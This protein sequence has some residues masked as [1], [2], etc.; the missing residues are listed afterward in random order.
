MR[1][2]VVTVTLIMATCL[3][4]SFGFFWNHPRVSHQPVAPWDYPDPPE[5]PLPASAGPLLG[6]PAVVTD[7]PGY[8]ATTA[9]GVR[10]KL[11]AI[12]K[13]DTQDPKKMWTP[14]GGA[15]EDAGHFPTNVPDSQPPLT[16]PFRGLLM[17]I[18]PGAAEN[19]S[20]Q[21]YIPDGA[22]SNLTDRQR[23]DHGWGTSWQIQAGDGR[24]FFPI[25]GIFLNAPE[26][27]HL[28]FGVAT[29]E[30]RTVATIF[31]PYS[32]APTANAVLASGPWGAATVVVPPS[33][34]F[35]GKSAMATHIELT[36]PDGKPVEN[37]LR[38]QALDNNGNALYTSPRAA[39]ADVNWRLLPKIA[40]FRVLSRPYQF[41]RFSNI[42]YFPDP[43]KWRQFAWGPT[44][45][46]NQVE[47]GGIRF[48]LDGLGATTLGTDSANRPSYLVT[49]F[50]TLN[51][52]IWR[53]SP[54]NGYL[55]GLSSTWGIP[56]NRPLP[57]PWV[58]DLRPSPVSALDAP[59]LR[60]TAAGSSDDAP[61]KDFHPE[62]DG[63]P[64]FQ[65]YGGHLAPYLTSGSCPIPFSVPR[66]A[67]YL[68]L[69]IDVA[70][71]AWQHNQNIVPD[72]RKIFQPSRDHRDWTLEV[73]PT[74]YESYK[75]RDG[76]FVRAPIGKFDS[77]HLDMRVVAHMKSGEARV[78]KTASYYVEDPKA[79][80]N[81]C[82]EFGLDA[83][84]TVGDM[85]KIPLHEI[86]F[87]EI[88]SRSIDTGWLVQKLP[89]ES[90]AH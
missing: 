88:Q 80:Y 74:I 60:I 2:P 7:A 38:L 57:R 48:A 34:R 5:Q 37:D 87:L 64:Q 36:P 18:E 54:M 75:R 78:L 71:G 63:W 20:Y 14:D 45:P 55:A 12:K 24:D 89:L 32:L 49:D 43:G 58:A 28:M 69:K 15:Y 65:Q 42:H 51:G 81:P 79:P 23:W 67:T 90:Q 53:D 16:G 59:A 46:E 52:K 77:L 56:P 85:N 33:Q 41:V 8:S 29:G 39:V 66:N 27:T 31:N 26:P 22:R 70:N 83:P 25:V 17:E 1:K 68:Q 84:M 61:G 35:V 3:A 72:A 9:S 40:S 10:L 73:G 47:V 4:A 44:Q 21:I 30:Y 76:R 6:D 19:P 13:G 86:L 11:V 50:Y 82:Y 62:S